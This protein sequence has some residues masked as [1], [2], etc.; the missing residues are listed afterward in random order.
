MCR[1]KGR[2]VLV[3][4]VGL[5]LNRADFYEKELDFFI[6]TSYGPGRYDRNYEERGLDYPVRVRPMD[7]E[8]E[9]GRVLAARG[10]GAR[11]AWS[12][13]RRHLPGRRSVS[14]VCPLWQEATAR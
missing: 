11:R 1:R 4:D 2:V 3:G 5:D 6:S 14:G 12:H 8:P 7:R 9:H 10:R 13:H